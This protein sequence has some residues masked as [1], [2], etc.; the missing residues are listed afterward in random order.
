[1]LGKLTQ[2]RLGESNLQGKV[3]D[4][5][6][7]VCAAGVRARDLFL[8]RGGTDDRVTEVQQGSHVVH[9]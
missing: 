8:L 6:M 3:C 4:L 2:W 7:H 9:R 5:Y 1:M